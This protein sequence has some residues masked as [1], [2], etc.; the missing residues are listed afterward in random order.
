MNR[1][2]R[3]SGNLWRTGNRKVSFIRLILEQIA[4]NNT[5]ME[6]EYF[7]LVVEQPG[8]L[9]YEEQPHCLALVQTPKDLPG[10]L[11]SVQ[12]ALE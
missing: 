4:R 12:T 9:L 10:I 6:A 11:L 5:P 1:R 3:G 2:N 7:L 8:F